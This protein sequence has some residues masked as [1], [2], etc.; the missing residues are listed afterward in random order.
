MVDNYKLAELLHKA[1]YKGFLAV[2]IDAPA[3]EWLGMEDEAIS[4]SVKNLKK[5]AAKFK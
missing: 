4:I 5:I 2:E 1:G 3:P